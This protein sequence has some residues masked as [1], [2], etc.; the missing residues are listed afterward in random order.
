MALL[1]D[2]H[3]TQIDRT[4]CRS[5]CCFRH[6]RN[7]RSESKQFSILRQEFLLRGLNEN[8]SS[9]NSCCTLNERKETTSIRLAANL[10]RPFDE[11]VHCPRNKWDEE[12]VPNPV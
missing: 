3:P 8:V 5:A 7:Q 6:A 2:P 10:T 1:V 9:A 11:L 12:Q 4:D